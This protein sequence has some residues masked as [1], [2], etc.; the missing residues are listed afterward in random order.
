MP[1]L[2]GDTRPA[3]LAAGQGTIVMEDLG[4]GP[5]LAD[6]LLDDDRGAAECALLAWAGPLGRALA[7]TRRGRSRRSTPIPLSGKCG[8]GG[9]SCRGDRRSSTTAPQPGG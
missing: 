9:S 3:L 5:S 8:S 1:V 2:P 6:L 7:A 4:S